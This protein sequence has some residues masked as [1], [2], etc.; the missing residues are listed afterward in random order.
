MAPKPNPPSTKIGITEREAG[1]MSP[2][3]HSACPTCGRWARVHTSEEGTS[4]FVPSD[5][6]LEA[7]RDRLAADNMAMRC[8]LVDLLVFARGN[9]VVLDKIHR[10]LEPRS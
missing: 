8:A 1:T 9:Q 2:S 6:E 3:A 5:R 4:Y 7:E 10:A